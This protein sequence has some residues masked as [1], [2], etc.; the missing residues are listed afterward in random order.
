MTEHCGASP[1][2][3]STRRIFRELNADVAEQR[4]VARQQEVRWMVSGLFD[5]PTPNS[6]CEYSDQ[7]LELDTVKVLFPHVSTTLCTVVS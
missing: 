5:K 7:Q 4:S 1:Q 2:L 3:S 6:S